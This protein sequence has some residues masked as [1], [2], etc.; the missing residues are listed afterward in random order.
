[1]KKNLFLLAIV[2]IALIVIGSFLVVSNVRFYA[3]SCKTFSCPLRLTPLFGFLPMSSTDFTLLSIGIILLII[4]SV[5]SRKRG[6]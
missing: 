4:T 6:I 1:M 5:L 3:P 2:G